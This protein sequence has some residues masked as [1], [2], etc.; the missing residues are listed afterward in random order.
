M[1]QNPNSNELSIQIK[2]INFIMALDDLDD[3]HNSMN[4]DDTS[5]IPELEKRNTAYWDALMG[6]KETVYEHL[7][8]FNIPPS[9]R[10]ME[11]LN[12]DNES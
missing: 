8:I 10:F 7:G 1:S 12:E 9:P 5:S 11:G 2:A 4:F 6:L 3:Y